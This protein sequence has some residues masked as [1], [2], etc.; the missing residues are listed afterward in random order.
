VRGGP[1]GRKARGRRSGDQRLKHR[2]R[3][4]APGT[5]RS[6]CGAILSLAQNGGTVRTGTHQPC[7][8]LEQAAERP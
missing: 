4:G 8:D 5:L 1:V 3:T 6:P 2:P 7:R